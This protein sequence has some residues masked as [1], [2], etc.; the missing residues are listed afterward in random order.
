MYRNLDESVP[1]PPRTDILSRANAFAMLMECYGILF[2][3]SLCSRYNNFVVLRLM[4][5][6]YAVAFGNDFSC[7]AVKGTIS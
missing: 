7:N 5:V 3:M 6:T 1:P 2:V 4:G